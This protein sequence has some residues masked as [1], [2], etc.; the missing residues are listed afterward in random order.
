VFLG[1]QS[2]FDGQKPLIIP[3]RGGSNIV[4]ENTLHG[5]QMVISEGFTHFETDLR[6]SKDGEIFLHHDDSFNRT[7]DVEGKVKDFNWSEIK[8]INAGYEFYKNNNLSGYT[9]TFVR[10]EDALS[11]SKVLKFNLDLKETG[12]AK[13]V[14]EIVLSLNAQNRVLVS[15][16]SPSRLDEFLLESNG[17]I[18][19]SGT[20]RENA[21]ARFLP[22]KKR[23]FQVQAL[24]A[25]FKWKGMQI[26]SKKLVNFCKLNNLQLHIWTVN[27][28]NNLKIC[29]D[30]GCDGI[31]TDEPLLFR[32]YLNSYT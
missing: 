26:Y 27:S 24:Q 20:F 8:N 13:K 7:T 2:Y 18:V 23:N 10:L 5:L 15:S 32:E 31:I 29:L 19:T 28:I 16:F 11:M 3:H 4:P 9:T 17:Q 30:L 21:I 6:M 12:L 25:P 1:N 22:I 14:V